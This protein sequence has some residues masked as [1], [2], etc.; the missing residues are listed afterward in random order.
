MQEIIDIS[1]Y[2]TVTDWKKLKADV[3]AIILKAS[4]GHALKS[5]DYL[6]PD[7]TFHK[8][9]QACVSHGIPFGAYHFFTGRTMADAVKE[10]DYFAEVLAPY[11]SKIMYA[12]CDAE[13]YNNKWLLGLTRAELSANISAFCRRMEEHGY[14]A[15]HYTNTDHIQSFINVNAIP[16]PVWQAQYGKTKPTDAR[17]N[18]IAWQYTDKGKINGIREYTDRNHGYIPAPEFAIIKLG[19]LD[20]LDSPKYWREGYKDLQYLDLL[21]VKS[22]ARIKKAGKPCETLDVALIRMQSAGVIDT[23]AYW[24]ENAVKKQYLPDLIRKLGGS[25]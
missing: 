14:I 22:A 18:L 25:V 6:F 11:K 12:V 17:G 19:A 7:K 23:P 15:A 9:A 8:Y 10:A 1:H 24:R 4:Q 2:Q 20:V 5:N 21:F 13:N 3:D 16:Y